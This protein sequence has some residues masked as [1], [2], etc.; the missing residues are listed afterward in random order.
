M[1]LE[2]MRRLARAGV[3]AVGAAIA[4]TA[5]PTHA[6]VLDITST[7]AGA[8]DFV[9][10]VTNPFVASV[11]DTQQLADGTTLSGAAVADVFAGHLGISSSSTGPSTGSGGDSYFTITFSISDAQP[12]DVLKA[13]MGL[14]GSF[15]P[16]SGATAQLLDLDNGAGLLMAISCNGYNDAHYGTSCVSGYQTGG[17][18]LGGTISLDIPLYGRDTL[19]LQG[20]LQGAFAS[21]PYSL[22]FLNSA[23]LT[24]TVPSGT[25]VTGNPGGS[26]IQG[27]V[28]EPGTAELLAAGLLGAGLVRTRGRRARDSRSG[29]DI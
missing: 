6:L 24:F 26:L 15:T 21:A 23:D 16:G 5:A 2:G 11:S 1:A 18:I 25:S 17:P 7:E 8:A 10:G 20:V 28:P 29:C 4:G 14:Q 19:T 12:G 27:A 13:K 3:V 9:T 22:D